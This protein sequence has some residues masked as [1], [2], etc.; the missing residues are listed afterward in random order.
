MVALGF[1][2]GQEY[3]GLGINATF[4]P[5]K[6]IGLFAGIGYAFAGTGYNAGFKLRLIPEERFMKVSPWLTGMYGYNAAVLVAD[7]DE[8]NKLFY[9]PSAGGGIDLRF[10]RNRGYLSIGIIIPFRDVEVQE[11][12]DM[13][14]RD[15]N[16]DF[17]TGLTP[18]TIAI[19]Y[20]LIIT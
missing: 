19:G 10:R 5:Q 13:L 16:V 7:K 3:G 15:K 8:Y 12:M 17:G 2:L 11:Y 6:N 9:G 1:G 4:Y 14:E 20:K 18:F